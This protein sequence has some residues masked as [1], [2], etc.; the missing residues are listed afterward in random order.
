MLAWFCETV[1]AK[2]IS[3]DPMNRMNPRYMFGIWLGMRNNS[4]ECFVGDA[5]GGIQSL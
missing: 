1:L 4:A 5:D 3:K 2:K